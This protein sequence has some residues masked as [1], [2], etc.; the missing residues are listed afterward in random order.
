MSNCHLRGSYFLHLLPKI[1]FCH[2]SLLL[3]IRFRTCQE[4]VTK[5]LF[6]WKFTKFGHWCKIT[7]HSLCNPYKHATQHQCLFNWL[8]SRQLIRRSMATSQYGNSLKFGF[9][10][11]FIRHNKFF[12]KQYNIERTVL[13]KRVAMVIDCL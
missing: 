2:F 12:S 1:F 4:N 3:C 5:K 6:N 9:S 11:A 7:F 13:W 8:S 10:D